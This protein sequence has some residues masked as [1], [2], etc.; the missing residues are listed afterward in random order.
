[1][2][3]EAA[4]WLHREVQHQ[5]QLDWLHT[6][7]HP[8]PSSLYPPRISSIGVLLVWS[9]LVLN[10]VAGTPPAICTH[11]QI[12]MQSKLK[13]KQT[14][15][16][17]STT[18]NMVGTREW[19]V[20]QRGKGGA[21]GGGWGIEGRVKRVFPS[22]PPSLYT[23]TSHPPTHLTASTTYHPA[24]TR[25]DSAC[26]S[27]DHQP[28]TATT[29]PSTPTLITTTHLATTTLPLSTHTT[30]TAP[31]ATHPHANPHATIPIAE[32]LHMLPVPILNAP[33]PPPP[34]RM[35]SCPLSDATCSAMSTKL[36][37]AARY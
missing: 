20:G 27:K 31:N 35:D 25:E 21:K 4:Q 15:P 26:S 3:V 8:Q 10:Y 22:P 11:W 33:P 2:V 14:M 29:T 5:H 13:K 24:P 30:T 28:A 1:M 37:R 12:T 9:T 7:P 17:C 23:K 18:P 19:R 16:C 6:R 32:Y 36:A 34:Q